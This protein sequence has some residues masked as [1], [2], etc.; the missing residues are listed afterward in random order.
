L[1]FFASPLVHAGHS[2][3]IASPESLGMNARL[4]KAGVEKVEQGDYG[5][6]DSLLVLRGGKLVLEK[7]FEPEYHGRDYRQ[8][9]RSVTKSFASALIGIAI[10]QRHIQGVEITLQEFF[11]E[12]AT[13]G[14][15]DPRKARITLHD[16][17]SM[18]A[19]YQWDEM[20]RHYGDPQN[21]AN[22]MLRSDDWIKFVL[23]LPMRDEPGIRLE[24]N[25]GLSLLLSAILHKTTGQSAED[26]AAVNLFGPM[27]ID[28]W[29]WPLATGELTGTHWGLSLTRR[30][31]AHFGQ[32]YL[33]QGRWQDQQ[34][35]P[36]G[37]VA[38]STGRQIRGDAG[39]LYATYS[40]GY[41]WWRFRDFD[42]TVRDLSVNDVFFAYGDGGQLIMVVP[43]LDLVVV[44]TANL[45]RGD[46][47]LQFDLIRDHVFAA[48]TG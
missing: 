28:N 34:I 41:Q 12:Y 39:S 46:F 7:Y 35:I 40:Y 1:A 47:Q 29:S 24:Y 23:D 44:S 19:G 37:W 31:M 9:V 42:P 13:V 6:I 18:S 21:D 38:A 20:I 22:R 3:E 16:V 30:G 26:F 5:D 48:V 15:P 43:H 11:P 25:S 10:M 32:L 36:A 14:N 4:L 27:G 2:F 45:F 8:P 33:D 17:L